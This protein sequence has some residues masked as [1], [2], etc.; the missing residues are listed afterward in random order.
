M[1]KTF[2]D[3]QFTLVFNKAG[4][5]VSDYLAVIG[6][7]DDPKFRYQVSKQFKIPDKLEAEV[8]TFIPDLIDQIKTN[9]GIDK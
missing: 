4:I 3:V 5:F 1:S 7:S 9:E 2:Q 8:L 6:S